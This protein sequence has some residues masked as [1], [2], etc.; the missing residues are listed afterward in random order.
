MSN[1]IV[2]ISNIASK[3]QKGDTVMYAFNKENLKVEA[4]KIAGNKAV[5]IDNVTKQEYIKNLDRNIENLIINMKK[6]SYKPKA[7]R[8][9][10]IPK[11]GSD[12]KRH[13]GIP[14]FEDKIVQVG[15]TNILN[16]IYEP[17]F[18]S[19]SF[20]CRPKMSCHQAIA[21]LK[22]MIEVKDVN[23]IVDLDIKGFFD[24]IDHEWLIKFLEYRINDRTYIRYI[25]RFLKSGILE[26]GKPLKSDKGT[27]QGG[28]ISP[29]LGNIYLH[30]VLDDWFEKVVRKETEG[31]SGMVRYADDVV[32]C[33][34]YKD[35][36]ERFLRSV[37]KRLAKFGLEISEEKTKILEF[38]RNAISNHKG[39]GE[40][41]PETFEFLGFTFY[42]STSKIGKFRVKC[43]TS[44]K[45][46]RAKVQESKMWIKKRMHGK[47]SETIK[48][49]NVKLMG[50]YRYYGITDNTKGIRQYYQT[51]LRTLYKTLNRRTQRNKYSFK[52]Y[53]DKI[54]KYIL[55]PKVY[56]NMI[57][58][59]LKVKEAM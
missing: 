42:C 56:I 17:M 4:K 41:K 19:F 22:K 37:K 2:R 43:T 3:Y 34:R 40:R 16:A 53:Y 30:F 9:V 20:G 26:Q 36:A 39:R 6:M 52:E 24:N 23:Y 57:D 47:V 14:A 1:E 21:Y 18:K 28:I 51:I 35:E 33:F 58:M 44:K 10:Y 31:Y 46:M 55:K 59:Q 48:L 7:V 27:P 11:P 32:A 15:M 29:V 13:L 25:K 12:K 45:K 5:G 54:G 38:G 8:R 50:H 49:L